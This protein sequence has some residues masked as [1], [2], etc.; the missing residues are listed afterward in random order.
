M[1]PKLPPPPLS[2]QN[3]SAF[4]CSFATTTSPSAV[5]TS[6]EIRLSQAKPYLRSSQ[7][8]PLPVVKPTTPVRRH[9]AAGHGEP[10]LLRLAVEARPS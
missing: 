3:R 1:T 9:A 6:A 8:L 4:S 10:E 5:T 2:A 7:P